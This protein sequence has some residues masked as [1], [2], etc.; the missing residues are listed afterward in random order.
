MKRKGLLIPLVMLSIS[1]FAQKFES[2]PAAISGFQDKEKVKQQM[3]LKNRNAQ[4]DKVIVVEVTGIGGGSFSTM[5]YPDGS[6]RNN[7]L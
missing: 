3:A 6:S 4:D 1:S 5:N 2:D 7:N